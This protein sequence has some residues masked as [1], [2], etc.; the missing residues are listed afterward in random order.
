VED[1]LVVR[2]EPPDGPVARPLLEHYVAD[3]ADRYPGWHP[4]I[5]P[6]ANP[7]DFVGDHG[8][9]VVVLA[10]G[11]PVGCGG[12]KRLDAATGEV[13]RLYVVP[14]ARGRGVAGRLLDE[15]EERARAFGC[16]RVRLDTGDR[17]PEALRLF[18]AAG[19][20]EIPAY[21]H[22]PTARFWFEKSL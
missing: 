6:S 17:Q 12:L 21:N 18:R 16:W 13:K 1:S 11:E 3:I 14:A 19:Y 2:E 9:F 20:R 10:D 5:G 8:R 4:G 22:N 7:E 15:L